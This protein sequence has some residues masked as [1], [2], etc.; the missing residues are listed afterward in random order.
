MTV[1]RDYDE[2][3]AY[4]CSADDDDPMLEHLTDTEVIGLGDSYDDGRIDTLAIAYTQL[5]QHM[6]DLARIAGAGVTEDDVDMV[7][8]VLVDF[9]WGNY[10]L[11]EVELAESLDWAEALARAVIT[12]IGGL[13]EQGERNSK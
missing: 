10:R 4:W 2:D 1:D 13:H 8:D 11:D 3:V 12:K 9:D 7:K 6:K 5:R